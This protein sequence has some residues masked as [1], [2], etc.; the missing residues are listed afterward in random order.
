MEFLLIFIAIV[1]LACILF[2]KVA[3]RIGVPALLAFML[4]G[5]LFGIDGIFRID[6]ENYRF[7]EIGAG[8]ALIFIMFYGGFGTNWKLARPVA[9]Q[10]SLLASAG[11]LLTAL[12][13]GLFTHLLLG[14]QL[15]ESVLIGAILGSTDAASVFSILRSKRLNLRYGT[16][17]LLEIESGSNDPAAYMLTMIMIGVISGTSGDSIPLLLW[18]Q[19]SF[20]VGCGLLIAAL[21][22]AFLKRFPFATGGYGTVA[23]VAIALLAYALP[24]YFGGNGYL[25]AYLVGIILGNAEIPGKKEL[26]NFFD[27]ITGMMQMFLFF[28]LGLLATPS[29]IPSVLLPAVVIAVVMSFLVRPLVV[30][31][32]LRPLGARWNQVLLV[33]FAGLRGAASIVFAIMA[34]LAVEGSGTDIYHLVLTVVLFSILVQ[35][36]ALPFLAERLDMISADE[37]V[38]K[39]FNDYSEQ[40]PVQF[41]QFTVPEGHQWAGKALREL[42]F[43]PDTLLVLLQREREFRLDRQ[44]MRAGIAGSLR[45]RGYMVYENIVPKGDTQILPGDRITLAAKSASDIEG[46]HLTEK[47]V[48]KKQDGRAVM[49]CGKKNIGLVVMIERGSEIIIPDGQT[50]LREGDVLVLH[51]NPML[52]AGERKRHTA[53]GGCRTET[54]SVDEIGQEV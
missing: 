4:I 36:T 14:W 5:M 7:A 37:D 26:V 3:D 19:L 33:S 45:D 6:F 17:S 48:G 30:L 53:S 22:I 32:L 25:S 8:V 24:A 41:I 46:V 34:I 54:G 1:I 44:K 23:V 12:L 28:L 21:A 9:G 42:S 11:V 29:R 2:D 10:A 38:L 49:E 16:A 20:G 51:R 50:R 31:G 13:T 47:T 40:K 18:K 39:T 15:A 35:G 52:R 43:P 27:G